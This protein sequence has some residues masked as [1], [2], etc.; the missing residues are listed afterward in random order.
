MAEIEMEEVDSTGLYAIGFDPETSIGRA[1]FR[2]KRG[3]PTSLYEYQGC[4]QEEADAIKSGGYSTF[5]ALW[6][7]AK[8]YSRIE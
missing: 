2:D 3:N 5:S 1:R 8:Q 6:K 4:T 7:Y